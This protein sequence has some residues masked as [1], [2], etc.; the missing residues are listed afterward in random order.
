LIGRKTLSPAL[1]LSLTYS[2]FKRI[3]VEEGTRIVQVDEHVA[4]AGLN[5]SF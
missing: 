1:S 3:E 2:P 5:Y 4:I